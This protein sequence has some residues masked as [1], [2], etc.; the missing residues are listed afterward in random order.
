MGDADCP[1]RLRGC[2]VPDHDV[3]LGGELRAF[4]IRGPRR[5]LQVSPPVARIA[6]VSVFKPRGTWTGPPLTAG[7]SCAVKHPAP[8]SAGDLIARPGPAKSRADETSRDHALVL[9]AQDLDGQALVEIFNAYYPRMYAYGLAEFRDAHAAEDFASDVLLRVLDGIRNYRV[10]EKPF[11]SWI[12][13]IARNRLIDIRRRKAHHQ[14]VPL[15]YRTMDMRSGGDGPIKQLLDI[16]E[17]SLGLAGL[18]EAQAQVIVLRFLLDLD[19]A[20]AARILGR[21]ERAVK[22]LQF[23]AISALRHR[24]SLAP[25][26]AGVP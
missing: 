12:Y 20:S 8:A 16:D 10:L 17:I 2:C 22:S 4:P 5:H 14:H 23:R 11:S 13:R 24:L 15:D 1:H 25:A 21:S 26:R 7:P 6:R 19:L 18:T 3:H 9:R